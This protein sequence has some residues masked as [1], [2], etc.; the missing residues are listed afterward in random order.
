M[1][2]ESKRI[3]NLPQMDEMTEETNIVVEEG[4]RAKRIPAKA[5]PNVRPSVEIWLTGYDDNGAVWAC[6]TPY[7]TVRAYIMDGVRF[8]ACA[9]APNVY[10]NSI[11]IYSVMYAAVMDI[12]DSEQ[13][14]TG[15]DE[16]I[17]LNALDVDW[18]Q[19]AAGS[20]K[21]NMST[22]KYFPDSAFRHYPY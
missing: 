18:D 1:A 2:I 19:V 21:L 4:G 15:F 5:L 7:E 17:T 13:N 6:N 11:R 20:G 22:F 9:W 3:G 12:S 14:D 8:D 10:D 16:Y